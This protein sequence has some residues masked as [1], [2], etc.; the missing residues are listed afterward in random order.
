MNTPKFEIIKGK[1]YLVEK[2]RYTFPDGKYVL[3]PGGYQ[4]NFASIPKTFRWL[5]NPIDPDVVV[6][7]LVH[8][9]LVQEWSG[10]YVYVWP[11]VITETYSKLSH[12]SVDWPQ[13]IATMR[14][15]MEIEGA[16]TWKRQVI[17][18]AVRAYG[19]MAG[20]K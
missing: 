2:F 16:P 5:I 11:S 4:T 14:Q 9:W 1:F 10:P 20:K 15:I 6:A 17:Y 19:I 7:A 3:V 12:D 18:C 13:A 8:D